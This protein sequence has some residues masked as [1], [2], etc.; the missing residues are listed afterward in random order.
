M[1]KKSCV[2][3]DKSFD[4]R[5]GI[6][7]NDGDNY[8]ISDI[9]PIVKDHLLIVPKIHYYSFARTNAIYLNSLL[10]S[11]EIIKNYFKNQFL[12]N[13]IFFEHGGPTCGDADGC[14]IFHAHL[15]ALP[16]NR[17]IDFQE[18]FYSYLSKGK[19]DVSFN[20]LKSIH[21]IYYLS[22]FF[23]LMLIDN[24]SMVYIYQSNEEFESQI[25]R[26]F[27]AERINNDIDYSWKKYLN[28]DS[29]KI[30]TNDFSTYLK[31]TKL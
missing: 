11:I 14:G 21:H 31:S 28:S 16:L 15:H 18:D 9:S 25:L 24:N 29:A 2:F 13:F 7:F 4:D 17:N 8:I 23:Y 26:K 5:N 22:D 3:C 1:T 19:K 27:I 30:C 6:I 10:S 20:K 12:T